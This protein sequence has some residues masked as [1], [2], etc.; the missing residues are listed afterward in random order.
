MNEKEEKFT[1]KDKAEL[2]LLTVL[3]VIIC[4]QGW[5]ITDLRTENAEQRREIKQLEE[6]QKRLADTEMAIIKYIHTGAED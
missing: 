2:F 6:N 1:F 3:T 4:W 5:L